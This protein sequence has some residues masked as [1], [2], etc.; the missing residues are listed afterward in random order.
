[1]SG[2]S[3]DRSKIHPEHLERAALGYVRQ[4]SLKQVRENVESQR[5]QYG[6][7]EQARALGWSEGQIVILDEDQGRS[8]A[9]PQARP[10]LARRISFRL[11]VIFLCGSGG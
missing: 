7:A 10:G 2:E 1:M 5:R 3:L 4:S 11:R 6:F 8:G 9:A